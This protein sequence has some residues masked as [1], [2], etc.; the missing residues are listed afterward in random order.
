[1]VNLILVWCKWKKNFHLMAIRKVLLTLDVKKS[2]LSLIMT[3]ATFSNMKTVNWG[4]KVVVSDKTW[5]TENYWETGPRFTMS[6]T[7]PHWNI[8]A[9]CNGMFALSSIWKRLFILHSR[10]QIK[11]V[12]YPKYIFLPLNYFKK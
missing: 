9:I 11:V 7:C 2:Q 10:R 12:H 5:W 3:W 4:R 8:S 1:M 6:D